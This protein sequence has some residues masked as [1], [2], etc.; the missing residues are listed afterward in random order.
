MPSSTPSAEPPLAAGGP[1]FGTLKLRLLLASA[2]V[3]AASVAVSAL[4]VLQRVEHR[5]EQAVMD[6]E[7]D[8]AE[9]VASLL[10]QRVVGLQKMLRASADKLPPSAR[11]DAAAAA[12]FLSGNPGLTSN[13][14]MVFLADA[15]GQ[16]LT[17]HD[18]T[19]ARHPVLNLRDREYFRHTFDQGVPM[20]SAPLPGR[21][22]NEPI[23]QMTMPVQAERGRTVAVLGGTLRLGSRTLFDDLTYAGSSGR[24][25]VM[26]IVTDSQGTIIS[27]PLR[28]RVMRSVEAEPGLAEAVVRWVAQGR[29][30]EPSGFSV[31]EAGWF[32]SMAGVPGADWM[33]FRLA[34]DAE[35]MGG[36]AQARREA[37]Q[38]AAGV[39]L[40][41]GLIIG[42]L[43]ALLL[44]PLSRLRQRA[45]RLRDP[46]LALDAGWPQARGEIGELSRVLQQVLRERAQGEQAN[47]TLVQQMGSV[48]AAA[49]IGIAF[50]RERRFE[51]AGAEFCAL[52]GWQGDD[53][54]GRQAGEIFASEND[55]DALGPQVGLAFAAG[56]PYFG[57][58]QFR[59][60]DG[61]TFWGRLQGRPVDPGQAGAGTIWLLEDV[62]EHREVRERLSWS[63]S[64]DML[65]RLLN[66]AAFE[67]RLAQ[68]LARP[69]AGEETATLICFDLDRFKLINDSAGHAA[70]DA[71]LREV[72]HALQQQVRAG[73]AAARL[74]GDEFALLLPDCNTSLALP[75]AERLREALSTIGI[76]HAGR[77]LNIGASL[78][79]VQIDARISRDAAEWLAR[80]DAACYEAKRGG[81][82]QVRLAP[83]YAAP[84]APE[85]TTPQHLATH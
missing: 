21:L 80:A 46:S 3:I 32:V 81:R 17:V 44:G 54:V 1:L 7:R 71:V 50:T 79:L 52:L 76:D 15:D 16:L 22:S 49:P 77:R 74:G 64:H 70:G 4:V 67:E 53:L 60:R 19:E 55:Y 68:W 63:A 10:G 51:L 20:V 11:T 75:L 43:V 40:L 27:H 34:P 29:P 38:W 14:S 47:Q 59:R 26:T 45:L 8:N 48:L 36:L 65:T 61:S 31:H 33:V 72:A 25:G 84:L 39:A 2:V 57:E 37:L 73:D 85:R 83:A 69:Q 24:E 23:I 6:L 62:T 12:Q 82:D 30:V 18:G 41:G 78:G 9:R 42:A 28:E 66:R 5:S 56:R 13:F 35:L 58:L